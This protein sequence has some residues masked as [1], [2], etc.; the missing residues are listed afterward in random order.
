MERLE[1]LLASYDH[2]VSRYMS[3]VRWQD[4][5]TNEEVGRRFGVE[6]LEQRL[7]RMRLRWF[8]HVK[9][10]SENSILRRVMELEVEGRSPVGRP[11]KTW[12][13]VVE[14]DMRKLNI[15]EDMAEERKQWM[16]LIPR[17]TPGVEN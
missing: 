5:I 16:Q 13:K 1:G 4:R 10:R 15:T 9:R 2:R 11:K 17:P 8:G 6:N 14:E 3:R 12:S 7:R